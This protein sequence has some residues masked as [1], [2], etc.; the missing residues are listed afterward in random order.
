MAGL[1]GM[2]PEEQRALDMA[3]GQDLMQA[4]KQ[5]GGG[6]LMYAPSMGRMQ[7][8]SIMG[9]LQGMGVS[10][11]SQ[12]K[13]EQVK[14][15][16]QGLDYNNPASMMEAARKLLDLGM[17]AEAQQLVKAAQ[18]AQE[19]SALVKSREATATKNESWADIKR[20]EAALKALS[21]SE[22]LATSERIAT[23][24][25][26]LKRQLAGETNEIKRQELQVKIANNDARLSILQQNA[27]TSR[28]NAENSAKRIQARVE[29]ARIN[30]ENLDKKLAMRSDALVN[31]T[32]KEPV[33]VAKAQIDF[34]NSVDD[35]IDQW[36]GNVPESERAKIISQPAEFVA[37]W[38][39]NEDDRTLFLNSVRKLNVSEVG[40]NLRNF[41]TSQFSN[42]DLKLA[43]DSVFDPETKPEVLLKWYALAAQRA[44]QNASN[45]NKIAGNKDLNARDI[46]EALTSPSYEVYMS[47]KEKTKAE[48]KAKDS[49]LPE[50]S[51]P[52]GR[53][54][55]GKIV[56]QKPNGETVVEE[57]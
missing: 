42:A 16:L 51:K 8:E 53:T 26:E 10:T 49:G 50:G 39:S 48:Q 15:A 12:R 14:A 36:F 41:G 46:Q 37:K 2:T 44:K 57:D 54:P 30:K 7:S 27:D 24:N 11:P 40:A 22:K 47:K 28:M 34:A 3:E 9:A 31:T 5:L 21:A 13:E 20:E 55:E 23:A 19:S 56:Y 25:N 38:L 4:G 43:A 45:I 33:E 17:T 18:D 52:I 35:F 6:M 32:L 1:F 29:E